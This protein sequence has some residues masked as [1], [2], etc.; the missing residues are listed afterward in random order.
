M[1]HPPALDEA[2]IALQR[3]GDAIDQRQDL[4]NGLPREGAQPLHRPPALTL[5]HLAVAHHA[6]RFASRGL[7]HLVAALQLVVQ[8]GQLPRAPDGETG[9][10]GGTGQCLDGVQDGLLHAMPPDPAPVRAHR[11]RAVLLGPDG[12][13]AAW[14]HTSVVHADV[15]DTPPV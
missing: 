11:R 5:L 3:R 9:G 8:Q 10:I 4:A 7:H 12:N 15:E 2:G 14:N 1:P 6:D 13:P